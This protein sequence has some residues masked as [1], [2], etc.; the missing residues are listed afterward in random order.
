MKIEGSVFLVTGG[1][2]G[3]GRALVEALLERAARVVFCGRAAQSVGEACVSLKKW[4]D[5]VIGVPCDVAK[6]EECH[7]L[8]QAATTAFGRVDCLVNN[9][10]TLAP[11][12]PVTETPPAVWQ[13]VLA[14]NVLGTVNM[15]RHTLPGMQRRGS[16]A[17]V[18]ISSGW[19]RFGEARVASY[20]ASKFAVE[21]LSQS[22]AAEAGDGIAVV[23]LNPGII[24]TAMLARAFEGETES[25][26]TPEDVSPRWMRLLEKLGPAMNG[27][28]LD[29]DQF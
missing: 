13:E 22:V 9:A 26:P 29:L 8:V 14:V 23:A 18:N 1:T 19:G 12:A 2:R 20:C 16:G 11:L 24:Q 3:I 5:A 17:I 15:I 7:A 21:G 28:S 25:Y 27:K 4:R 6:D 10:A